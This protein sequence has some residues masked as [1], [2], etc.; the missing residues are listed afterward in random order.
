MTEQLQAQLEILAFLG[1]IALTGG[2]VLATIA[3]AVAGHR[4]GAGI[5]AG[6]LT[7][8]VAGY[9][10][11]LLAV[12]AFSR[13]RVLHPGEAK[14]FCEIDCHLAYSVSGTRTASDVSGVH[15]ARGTFW[16]VTLRTRFDERTIAPWRGDAPLS[17]NPRR[18]RLVDARGRA[19]PIDP[20]AQ[21]ALAAAGA[22]GAPLDTPLRP[23][24][25]YE[26]T[27]AFDVPPDAAS[28][29]LELTEA[30]PITRLIVGHEN[31]LLHGK[32]LLALS[33][34]G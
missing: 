21:H 1:T 10:A 9:A 23:G 4:R 8:V 13:E 19:W 12:G 3:L 18:V 24:E 15:A 2:G 20:A 34:G 22:A 27:L 5:A 29:S 6:G 17:P 33:P 14:V 32:T 25:S 16:L 11:L 26:T 31:S 7:A 30:D 28:P